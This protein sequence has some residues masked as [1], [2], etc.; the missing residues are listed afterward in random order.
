MASSNLSLS[1][2]AYMNFLK[3]DSYSEFNFY[4]C[5]NWT[6]DEMPIRNLTLT[7]PGL[8]KVFVNVRALTWT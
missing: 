6:V 3:K 4:I 8:T 2:F 5:I 7:H 1:Y